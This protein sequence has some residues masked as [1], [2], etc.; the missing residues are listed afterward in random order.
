MS[1]IP[2]DF[3]ALHAPSHAESAP[4]LSP[5]RLGASLYVPANRPDLAMIAHGQKPLPVRSLIFC[6]EDALHE[7]DLEPALNRLAALLPEL[8]TSASLR[9]IRPRN[10][11]V[12]RR[13]LRMDGIE[14]IQGF[15][16]PKIGP[17]TLG[18]WLRVWDDRHGHRLMPVLETTETLDRRQMEV[19]R[20][21]LEDGGLREQVLCLRIG[22]NDLLNLLGI[23]RAR[24]ATVYDTPLRSV[25][26][27]L[28]CVFHPA[29]YSLSAPVFE[30][31]DMPEALA[32][33][34]QADLQHGLVGKTAIHPTQ[35][36]VIE[37]QYR[38]SREDYEM[39]SATL[40]P[41]AAAVFK[42]RGT[43]CEPAT[44]QRWAAGI[45]ERAR[46]FGMGSI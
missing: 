45:L 5:T 18:D 36:P 24:G 14:Q 46:V 13:L 42:L 17:C 15:V 12:L 33:E 39:A 7:R 3:R 43:F 26:A 9:F 1:V 4:A 8:E 32:R 6:T 30:R 40:D 25:I 41:N 16:L 44:H 23:R 20:D 31:L 10:P 38:V 28:V 11:A 19:L 27:D 2:V 37:E 29:G 22:G 21:R 34:V 35:I